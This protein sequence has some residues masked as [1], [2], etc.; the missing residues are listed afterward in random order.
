MT[1]VA[2]VIS[3]FSGREAMG[4]TVTETVRRVPGEHHLITTHVVDGGQVFA[5]THELGG[6]LETFPLGRAAELAGVLAGMRP[7]L[8]HVHAGA[9]GP[10]LALHPALR[11]YPKLLTVYAWPTLPGPRAWR[12]GTLAE[13]WASNVLRPRVAATTVLPPPLAAAALRR[14][15]VTTILTP[16]PRV[17]DRLGRPGGPSIVRYACGAP[18]DERRARFDRESPVI[19]FAGRAETVRGLDTLLDAFPAVR[20][21]VPGVRLR[22]LLIPRPELPAILARAGSAGAAIDVVTEPVP[23]LL[24][25][26]AAAQV[27]TWPFKFDYTTSPPAMA[28]VEAM[29]VGLPVVGTDVACVRAVLEPGVNGLSVPPADPPAL[30]RALI[31]LLTDEVAWRR[32]AVAGRESARDHMGWEQATDRAAAAYRALTGGLAHRLTSG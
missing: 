14:A 9:L 15:G 27:G 21:R 18:D 4:R 29:A 16:D 31:S 5:G 12:R 26:F 6:S 22:L 8:V 28:L 30:A 11:P 24:G 13:M 7:D 1:R 2:H 3:E 25:E 20:E 32:Y 17:E 19:V 23:D 10:L